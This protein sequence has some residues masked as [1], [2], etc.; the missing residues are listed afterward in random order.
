MLVYLHK[1]TNQRSKKE[2]PEGL[3]SNTQNHRGFHS[4]NENQEAKVAKDIRQ[5]TELSLE[6]FKMGGG[7]T[8][9]KKHEQGGGKNHPFP[10][11]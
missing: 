6:K 11:K 3:E 1:K 5:G 4:N 8:S 10:S 9:S 2:K 7:S